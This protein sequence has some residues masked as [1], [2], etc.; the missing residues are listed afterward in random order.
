[1]T[2]KQLGKWQSPH[3]SLLY[4]LGLETHDLDKPFVGIVYPLNEMIPGHKHL[5]TIVE[6]VKQGVIEAGGL[7]FAFGVSAVCDGLAMGHAGMCHSLPTRD[8]LAQNVEHV[9]KAHQLDGLVFVPNCD[10]SVPG[11]AIAAMQLDLPCLFVSGGPMLQGRWQ[12]QPADLTTVFEAASAHQRGELSDAQMQDLERSACPTVGSCAGMFT[13]NSMNCLMEVMGLALPGNGTIPAVYAERERLAKT[14]GRRL[15]DLVKIQLKP[16]QVVTH[17]VL[18][19]CIVAD[20]AM[21]CSTN[22]V[23]HVMAI[24]HAAGLTLD[25]KRFDD[26]SET[27]PHLCKLSPAN[28]LGIETFH[29][30][31]GVGQLLKQLEGLGLLKT[32]VKTLHAPSLGDYLNTLDYAPSDVIRSGETAYSQRGGIRV[33]YGNLAPKGAVLKVAALSGDLKYFEGPALVFES[34]EEAYKAFEEKTIEKGSVIII[35]N[36]GPKGGPGMRE[37]LKMTAAI[38][39]S[40]LDGTVALVTDGRFSGGTNGLAIGHVC[41]E[42]YDGGPIGRVTTGDRVLI[43]LE[44]GILEVAFTQTARQH[45]VRETDSPALK[46]Y[47]LAVGD[48]S[49]GAVMTY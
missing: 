47:R 30:S 10:K 18:D 40:V 20:M 38:K 46:A 31:G 27:T 8:L 9:A 22:T 15:M 24:A 28:T 12:G 39:G 2:N 5:H 16:R 48:A 17:D 13:A 41:P 11:M 4:A 33:L 3:R 45:R 49:D 21:G 42:A 25:L 19:N 29:H 36:E 32:H 37:M 43:D 7:P 14:T 34:E 1:M 44:K 23:L 6:A 26:L 35:R